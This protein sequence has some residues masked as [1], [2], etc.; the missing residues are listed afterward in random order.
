MSLCQ[1]GNLEV[2]ETRAVNCAAPRSRSEM[3]TEATSDGTPGAA[4]TVEPGAVTEGA[5]PPVP[6]AAPGGLAL[7]EGAALEKGAAG[8]EAE[9]DD[10]VAEAGALDELAE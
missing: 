10:E 3:S 2:Q 8:D 6:D 7:E 9:G 1:T 5:E 4:G